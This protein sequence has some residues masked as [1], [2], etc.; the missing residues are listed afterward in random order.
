M[1]HM[2]AILDLRRHK[3][4]TEKF[5]GKHPVLHHYVTYNKEIPHSHTFPSQKIPRKL[6]MCS[7]L[8]DY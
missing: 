3:N 1:S 5:E 6:D 4:T 7:L 2:A 8:L